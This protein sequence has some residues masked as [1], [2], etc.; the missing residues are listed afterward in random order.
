METLHFGGS[1]LENA[2]FCLLWEF[3]QKLAKSCLMVSKKK[4]KK[5]ASGWQFSFSK[6]T[7]AVVG[8]EDGS[9]RIFDLRTCKSIFHTPPDDD[10]VKSMDCHRD[11]TLVIAGSAIGEAKIINTKNGKVCKSVENHKSCFLN[12]LL[13]TGSW[14]VVVHWPTP[15]LCRVRPVL[16]SGRT[17]W[18]SCLRDYQWRPLHLGNFSSRG[19]GCCY[20]F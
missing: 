3:Q 13:Y 7:R 20:S 15:C 18:R 6:G 1:I 16:S 19:Q 9:V 2:R 10:A 8:Y 14:E 12:R 4:I 17:I 5:I 11:N